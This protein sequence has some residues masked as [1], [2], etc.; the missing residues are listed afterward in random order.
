MLDDSTPVVL[1][2]YLELDPYHP[3]TRAV[4]TSAHKG[5]RVTMAPFA[6][7]L[8]HNDFFTGGHTQ[9]Q[10]NHRSS[11]N[12]LWAI[13]RAGAPHRNA[14]EFA[15]PPRVRMILQSTV[16]PDFGYTDS[17]DLDQFRDALVAPP[18]TR[19]HV[20]VTA[21]GAVIEY[22]LVA[23]PRLHVRRNGKNC[24][25]I[26]RTDAQITDWWVRKSTAAGL[27]LVT[28]PVIDEPGARKLRKPGRTGREDIDTDINHVRLTG[29]ATIIDPTAYTQAVRSGIGAGRSYGCGLLLT[30]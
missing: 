16:A 27:S 23:N 22:Q 28:D 9:T 6:Y 4:I 25:T 21:L 1:R 2:T 12:V 30:R 17:P 29:K 20:P 24:T 18:H 5:H 10:P 15:P 13:N 14:A 11:F 19:K 3:V 26:A 7:A 8:E